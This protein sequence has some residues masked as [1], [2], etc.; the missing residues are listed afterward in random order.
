MIL[1][2]SDCTTVKCLTAPNRCE[3]TQTLIIGTMPENEQ[4]Y[5]VYIY[6]ESRDKL[7]RVSASS[8]ISGQLE[9]DLAALAGKLNPY[10]VYYIF[11]TLEGANLSE[12][13]DITSGAETYIC[14]KVE[15]THPYNDSNEQ[16]II[17]NQTIA[18]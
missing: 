10:A 12:R 14:F 15:F 13:E 16:V 18:I 4:H 2:I 8:D 7:H 17:T 6:D 11:V 5:W 3:E 1:C 9:I